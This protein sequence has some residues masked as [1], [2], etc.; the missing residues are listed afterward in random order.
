M[1][2]TGAFVRGCCNRS[3]GGELSARVGDKP[4]ADVDVPSARRCVEKLN[5]GPGRGTVP[6]SRKGKTDGRDWVV[7]SCLRSL[8]PVSG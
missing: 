5:A 4:D 7:V 3:V 6:L 1:D 2:A 8:R